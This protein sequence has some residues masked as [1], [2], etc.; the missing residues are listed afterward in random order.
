MIFEAVDDQI[1][2]MECFFL[3]DEFDILGYSLLNILELFLLLSLEF[4]YIVCE[5]LGF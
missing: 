2:V 4:G 1:G 5:E 3:K